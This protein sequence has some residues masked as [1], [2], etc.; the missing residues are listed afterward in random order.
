MPLPTPEPGLVIHYDYL[1]RWEADQQ[2]EA[3]AKAR[4]AVIVLVAGDGPDV[5]V[6]PV[7]TQPA[8]DDRD[9]VEIPARVAAHLGF[10]T[11]RASRVM[12]DEVNMFR[13]PND[14]APRPGHA[15]GSFDYGFIPPRLFE[16][17]KQAVL[18]NRRAGKLHAVKRRS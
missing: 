12:V 5:A 4:P 14:L 13:W 17:I 15:S 16:R 11:A 10:D 18:A 9:T 2:R 1:W 7:T 6:V 3:A 8:P